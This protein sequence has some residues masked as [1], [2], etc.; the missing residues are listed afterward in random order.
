MEIWKSIKG[1][2]GLYEVSNLGRIKSLERYISSKLN[3]KRKL[4]TNILTENI[5]KRGYKLVVLCNDSNRKT[6]RIHKLVAITFLDHIPC[7]HDLI[8][9]H[10]N[11][12]KTDNRLCNLELITQ[13]ENSNQLHI[14]RS[15]KYTGVSWHKASKKWQSNIYINKKLK[16]LG[17]FTNEIDA[18]NAYQYALKRII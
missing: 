4:K 3:S 10:K 5:D 1:Y 6:L 7:G 14:K 12:I 11:C 16:Y 17:M 15:S 2:E 18:S 9:N 13:R 8:V